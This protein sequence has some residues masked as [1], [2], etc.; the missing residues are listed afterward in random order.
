MLKVKWTTATLAFLAL[1]PAFAGAAP[2]KPIVDL[3]LHRPYLSSSPCLPG[4]TGLV[5]GEKESDT[6]PGCFATA[7]D[8]QHPKFVVIDLGD[9]CP[10]SKV[11]VY[12]SA[13]GN[14]RTVSLACSQD[15]VTYKKLRDPDFIFGDGEATSLSV[16]FQARPARYVRVTMPDTWKGGLGGD[17]CLFLR[18]VEVF[19]TRSGESTSDSL[20]VSAAEPPAVSSR[21]IDIFKRYCLMAP[22]EMRLTVVGDW[23]VSGAQEESHWA[24]VLATQLSKR[25]SEKKVTLTAV[26]GAEGSIAHGLEWAKGTEGALAP[27][28]VILAYGAQAAAVAAEVGEFRAKYQELMNELLDNTAALVIAV[29][30]PPFLQLDT[31][32]F[33]DKAK[34][35]ST[36]PY[37]WAV[38]QVCQTRG[39]PLVR[40]ASVLARVPGD[41]K[42]LYQ[43]N[44]HLNE[45]GQRALGTALA[46]LLY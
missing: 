28:I 12:N 44:L 13:N 30:P 7:N 14:T 18:E 8:D 37:A 9:E 29:T 10:I 20:T 19:G 26:G 40:T 35:H 46:E 3:A 32:P 39:V 1:L 43:D 2:S 21:A 5:D 11:V 38:E 33:L 17:N 23:L 15:G 27:D 4:W 24:R 16:A 6:A 34:G 31:L 22:G 36:R 25:Y 41:K 45:E 42:A